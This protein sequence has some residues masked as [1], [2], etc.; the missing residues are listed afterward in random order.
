M[1]AGPLRKRVSAAFFFAPPTRIFPRQRPVRRAKMRSTGRRCHGAASLSDPAIKKVSTMSLPQGGKR[2]GHEAHFESP[3]LLRDIILG[4]ADGLTVPFALA[5][6][7]SGAT[8]QAKLV[9]AGGSAEVAAG[10]IAMGLGGFLAART[11][12]DHYAREKRREEDETEEMP[13]AERAEVAQIFR[14]Y[15]LAGTALKQVV[16]AVTSDRKRWVDFMMRFELG[17][18]EPERGQA[19]RSA[20]TIALSYC[21]GGLIPLIPYILMEDAGDAL[22]WSTGATAAALAVFGYVKGH[23]SAESP[24]R[25]AMQTTTIGLAAAGAA[26]YVARLVVGS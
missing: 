22:R 15:G 26:F 12:A 7:L 8:G 11:A 14:G 6:G 21:G 19:W 25:S 1:T 9:V 20:S 16:D 17:I 2:A 3:T 24:W 23:F 18:E 13:E 10:A 5:A 4:M